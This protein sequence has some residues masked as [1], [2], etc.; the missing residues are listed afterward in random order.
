MGPKKAKPDGLTTH[1]FT[2]ADTLY[3]LSLI[4]TPA[5]VLALYAIIES[6]ISQTLTLTQA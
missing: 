4:L 1:S 6:N 5:I 3:G 2:S